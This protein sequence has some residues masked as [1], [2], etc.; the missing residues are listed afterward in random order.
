[1]KCN[2]FLWSK[3]NLQHHYSS[4]QYHMILQK[5]LYNMM[6]KKHLWLLSMLFFTFLFQD[7]LMNRKFKRTEL[8]WNGKAFVTLITTIQ[9]FGV[10]KNLFFILGGKKLENTFIHQGWVKLIKSYSK[11]IYS[12]RKDYILSKCCSFELSI[13]CRI[14]CGKNGARL[15]STCFLSIKSAFLKDHVRLKTDVYSAFRL[16]FKIY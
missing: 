1:V 11:D 16:H 4:L 6:L 7:S 2:L 15:F 3:L 9:K 12:V 14:F 10:S 8:F 13:H 5:L